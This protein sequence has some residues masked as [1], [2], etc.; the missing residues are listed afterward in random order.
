MEGLG[1]RVHVRGG[2]GRGRVQQSVGAKTGRVLAL[3]DGNL[4]GQQRAAPSSLRFQL[5]WRLMLKGVL[6]PAK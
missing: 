6:F 5:V 2:G 3:V 1:L 4:Q